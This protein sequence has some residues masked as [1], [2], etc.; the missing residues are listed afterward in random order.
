MPPGE[1][2]DVGAGNGIATFALARDGWRV[3]AVEPDSSNTVGAGAIKSLMGSVQ[4]PV[5]LIREFGEAIPVDSGS[6]DLVIAR[7]V[8]HH[9]RDLSQLCRELV[10]VLKPGGTLITLRDHVI[11]SRE[12]LPQFLAAHPLH[13][14]YG[15]E[16]AYPLR[17]YREAL[18]GAGLTITRVVRP[19]DSVVNYAPYTRNDLRR[20]ISARSRPSFTACLW[21]VVLRSDR[22]LDI[23]LRALSRI[24]RKPGRL[25]SFVCH[26]SATTQAL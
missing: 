20:I 18:K 19:F 12:Q 17:T 26:K 5:N 8:L 7:Q 15:G 2:L 22:V 10:R 25:Y 1:A 4:L 24:D 3:T 9:A 14:I 11:S 13:A 23:V 16:C 21:D 6:M